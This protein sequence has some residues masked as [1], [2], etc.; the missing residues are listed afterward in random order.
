MPLK[1]NPDGSMELPVGD[2][3][4]FNVS[5]TGQEFGPDDRALFTLKS[6]AG[7][8]IK[9]EA[10]EIVDGLFTVFFVNSDTD[11]LPAGNYQYDIR[12]IVNPVYDEETGRIIDGDDVNTPKDPT[13]FVLKPVVGEV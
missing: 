1:V 6:A 10:F 13:R 3:G 8:I 11:R 2:T 9:E 12:F 7:E 4:S 5:V